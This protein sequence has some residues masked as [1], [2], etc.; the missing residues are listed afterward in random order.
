M[1]NL[2]LST[3]SPNSL[4]TYNWIGD[5]ECDEG[6]YIYNPQTNS[7]CQKIDA[8]EDRYCD[9][10][11]NLSGYSSINFSCVAINFNGGDCIA[12]GVAELQ[13]ETPRKLIKV[14]DILGRKI[15]KASKTEVKFYIYDDG[16]S[17]KVVELK[18]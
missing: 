14:I 15:D 2:Y 5:D 8:E 13:N 16:T 1:Y 6:Q 12:G 3:I 10:I 18:Q 9:D 4:K 17:K 11:E 7:T